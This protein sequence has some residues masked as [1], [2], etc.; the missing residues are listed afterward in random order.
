MSKYLWVLLPLWLVA[1]QITVSSVEL[2]DIGKVIEVNAKITQLSNHKQEVVSRLEG[3]V[4]KYFVKAGDSVKEGDKIALI[5]SI[6][7]SKM[8]AEYL[9]LLQQ[10]KTAKLQ[11]VSTKKLYKSGLA[12]KNTMADYVIALQE[13]RARLDALYAQLKSLSIKPTQLTKATD[14]YILYAH[15]KGTIGKIDISV[16]AN[17]DTTTSLM[18][19]VNHN[20]FYAIA[21]MSVDHAMQLSS[22]MMGWLT[23][24]EKNYPSHFVQVLPDIDNETQR[25]KVV[26][27]IDKYPKVM[28]LGTFTKMQIALGK[29]ENQLV[30]KKSALTLF[31]GEWVV[32]VP[33]HDVDEKEHH[34]THGHRKYESLNGD[35]PLHD[36]HAGHDH[37]E[38]SVKEEAHEG[39]GH[40]EHDAHEEEEAPYEPRVVEIVSYY[41]DEV[42]V[43]GLAEKEAY[44]SEGV[45]F[46]KS[47]LLKSSLG[48]HGH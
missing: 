16:H 23:L 26:F 10:S 15:D 3:H 44:V 11:V 27:K 41:G 21:Y 25:A 4:E 2:K 46:V 17:V 48:G 38:K 12:S 6:Q 37:E 35:A 40:G 22:N 47:M 8:T 9:A 45:Y 29:K 18:S 31:Q 30:I 32:F 28:L 42:V 24:G 7:L 5:E 1:E 34:D 39:H 14:K 43:K 33:H 19:I 20:D 36:E 13:I